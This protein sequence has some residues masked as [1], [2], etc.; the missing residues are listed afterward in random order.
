MAIPQFYGEVGYNDL[1][2]KMGHYA[3]SIGY[4]LVASPGNFFYSHCYAM[5][6][7]EPI[8]VTGLTA[9][10]KLSDQW[11]LLGGF[12]RGWQMFEDNNDKL[13]FLGGLKWH[14][15]ETKTAL[16]FQVNARPG[17]RRRHPKPLRLRD[18]VQ[19]TA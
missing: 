1:T 10:Y 4:E 8:L 13:D 7:S 2:V 14:N 3:P 18:G 6:F 15:D 19:A 16:S 9:D 11:N 17:R 5:A 12:N